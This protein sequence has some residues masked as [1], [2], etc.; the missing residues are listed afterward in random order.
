M[1]SPAP[2]Y[3]GALLPRIP[4]FPNRRIFGYIFDILLIGYF[5]TA[6]IGLHPPDCQ[7]GIFNLGPLF[8]RP[9]F[10]RYSNMIN[11]NE[12]SGPY[13]HI[14]VQMKMARVIRIHVVLIAVKKALYLVHL[15]FRINKLI[16][17]FESG[18]KHPDMRY[19]DYVLIFR[20][21]ALFDV[22]FEPGP[23]AVCEIM[24]L[25][26]L[27][28]GFPGIEIRTRE[29]TTFVIEGE[30]LK[31]LT[32]NGSGRFSPIRPKDILK[33]FLT[34]YLN[35][36]IA[37]DGN[38]SNSVI[39]E[40]VEDFLR[41][42]EISIASGA[43]P[44]NISQNESQFDIFTF[45]IVDD[46]VNGGLELCFVIRICGSAMMANENVSPY[47]GRT[48]E[49]TAHNSSSTRCFENHVF[50]PAVNGIKGSGTFFGPHIYYRNTVI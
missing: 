49:T 40:A 4:S 28:A 22:V 46:P 21:G 42:A 25:A 20:L 8:L 34:P 37:Y 11:R 48:T 9:C 17:E 27:I 43:T 13:R 45:L 23:T 5:R 15:A 1:N 31:V 44:R 10:I 50:L 12:Y 29:M 35:F 30:I 16:R 47:A 26:A 33:L 32:G 19:Y 2:I 14:P 36:V 39:T 41:H 24:K 7:S 6:V 3:A 18:V 38:V